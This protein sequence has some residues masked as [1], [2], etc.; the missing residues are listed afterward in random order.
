MH[1]EHGRSTEEIVLTQHA[2]I[3]QQNLER[4][5][6]AQDE[7]A[8]DILE[9]NSYHLCRPLFPLSLLILLISDGRVDKKK[10]DEASEYQDHG[11]YECSD[12]K[13]AVPES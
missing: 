2:D 5:A 1:M 13:Y 10:G 6:R 9:R 8:R 12:D 4:V 11:E 7:R 3:I